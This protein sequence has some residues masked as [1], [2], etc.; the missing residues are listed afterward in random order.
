MRMVLLP[1][2]SP[3]SSRSSMTLEKRMGLYRGQNCG[4]RFSCLE[5]MSCLYCPACYSMS[6]KQASNLRQ[7]PS[8]SSRVKLIINSRLFII[9]FQ[10]SDLVF[11]LLC[12]EIYSVELLFSLLVCLF[13]TRFHCLTCLSWTSL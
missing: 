8:S 2:Q 11:H 13:E 4:S 7:C 3:G 1:V 10:K 9:C 12:E 6:P 5:T